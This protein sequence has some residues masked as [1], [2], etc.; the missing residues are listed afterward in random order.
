MSGAYIFGVNTN[1]CENLEKATRRVKGG[2]Y[3]KFWAI[4]SR[5][6]SE[7]EGKYHLA[8]CLKQKNFSSKDKKVHYLHMHTF[9]V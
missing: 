3:R 1:V 8:M 5:I 4:T 7:I 6:P 9:Y 2:K